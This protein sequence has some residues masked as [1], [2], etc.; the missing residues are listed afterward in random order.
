LFG[1]GGGGGGGM[2]SPSLQQACSSISSS[3]KFSGLHEK[4]A[5]LRITVNKTIYIFFILFKIFGH[6]YG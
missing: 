2:S 4:K 5:E 1:G 3:V 6:A